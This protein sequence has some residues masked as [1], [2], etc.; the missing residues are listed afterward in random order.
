MNVALND[1]SAVPYFT[2]MQATLCA[3]EIKTTDFD[4]Y[5][6]DIETNRT[7]NALPASAGWMSG[8]ELA[9]VLATPDL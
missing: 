6:S 1:S 4:W 5:I 3:A 2:D 8:R 9:E 7:L